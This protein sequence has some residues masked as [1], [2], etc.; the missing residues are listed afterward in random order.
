MSSREH[1]PSSD[2]RPI[3]DSCPVLRMDREIDFAAERP[4]VEP[5]AGISS[6]L[7][8]L[9]IVA[10]ALLTAGVITGVRSWVGSGTPQAAAASPAAA[11]LADSPLP[12]P[13]AVNSDPDRTVAGNVPPSA[14]NAKASR[15]LAMR[16]PKAVGNR[17]RRGG[18]LQ[19]L[20]TLSRE[21]PAQSEPLAAS[22][23]E[24]VRTTDPKT[25][26]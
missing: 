11:A 21:E 20:P 13:V 9:S 5:V 24:P 18:G 16:T 17:S 8:A 4:A 15:P 1:H 10:G 2:P 14:D 23:A 19:A 26:P 22:V 25:V 12:A 6:T 3:A 7:L